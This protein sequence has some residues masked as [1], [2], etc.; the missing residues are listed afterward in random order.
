[1]ILWDVVFEYNLIE[2]ERIAWHGRFHR[3]Q[4]N[5]Y[6]AVF[7]LEG[8][9]T[10]LI[11]A[12]QHPIAKGKFFL[13]RGDT[14]HQIIPNRKS[15]RP[16]AYYAILFRLDDDDEKFSAFLDCLLERFGQQTTASLSLCFQCEEIAELFRSKDPAL[17]KAAEY[18]FLSLLYRVY[19]KVITERLPDFLA[20]KDTGDLM[21]PSFYAPLPKKIIRDISAS[22]MAAIHVKKAVAIME[23]SLRQSIGMNEIARLLDLSPEYFTRIFK[24]E[25]KMS[26]LQYFLRLKIEGAAGLLISTNKR[27]SEI[28]RWFGFENQFQFSRVFKR[29][30]SLSPLEYRKIY[31]QTVDFAPAADT[32]LNVD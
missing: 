16:V 7:F 10:F 20:T 2:D 25:I 5:E 29:Y 1:M 17:A 8:S 3:H 24:R 19:H 31:L 22:E 12:N 26:P 15:G 21:P 32:V 11:G 30:T 18:S 13:N 14:Y 28:A 27:A 4:S 23:K 9:G 6:E